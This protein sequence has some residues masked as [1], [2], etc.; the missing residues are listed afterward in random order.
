MFQTAHKNMALLRRCIHEGLIFRES[1][2]AAVE[3]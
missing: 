3:R 1:A 2:I